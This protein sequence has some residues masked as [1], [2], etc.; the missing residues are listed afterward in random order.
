MPTLFFYAFALLALLSAILVIVKKD[1]VAS[2]LS[3]ILVFF[4]FAGIYALLDAHLIAA[5]QVLVYA[6]AVM[7]LFVFV[8]MLLH[9]P[10]KLIREESKRAW[11]IVP[12]VLL[13]FGQ[14]V[15]IFQNASVVSFQGEFSAQKVEALGGNTQ[16]ISEMMFSKYLFPFE[17]IS[18]LLLA[19][20]VGAIT[21]SK[22]HSQRSWDS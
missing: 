15:K 1:P 21:L 3:L 10:K 2:A 14:L 9:E 11:L 18:V 17:F 12:G 20:M 22:R 16:V 13:F 4:A 5:L 6:G 8:I 19:A 7:V